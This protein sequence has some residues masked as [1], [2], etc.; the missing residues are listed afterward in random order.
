MGKCLQITFGIINFL[1]WLGGA[2][3][4]GLSVWLVVNP[5]SFFDFAEDTNNLINGENATLPE[6]L[7]I[8]TDKIANGLYLSM[9]AGKF[10]LRHRRH[11]NLGLSHGLGHVSSMCKSQAS[12]RGSGIPFFHVL[13]LFFRYHSI[14]RWISWMLWSCAKKSMHAELICNYNGSCYFMNG[15]KFLLGVLVVRFQRLKNTGN[16]K[17]FRLIESSVLKNRFCQS[18]PCHCLRIIFKISSITLK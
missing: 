6:E 7:T 10:G 12:S 8:F 9:A 14:A 18:G 17:N 4:F 13:G 3:L 2:G 1:L 16:D 11:R 15:L 5:E